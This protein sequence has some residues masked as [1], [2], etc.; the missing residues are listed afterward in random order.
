MDVYI[1]F[2]VG[3][4]VGS[5]VTFIYMRSEQKQGEGNTPQDETGN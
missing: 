4:I 3:Y 2:V 1:I 5:I